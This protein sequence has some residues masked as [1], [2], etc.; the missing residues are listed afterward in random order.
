MRTATCELCG[1]MQR[2]STPVAVEV[3]NFCHARAS[4]DRAWQVAVRINHPEVGP[5]AFSLDGERQQRVEVGR[6][7]RAWETMRIR[8]HE[9]GQLPSPTRKMPVVRMTVTLKVGWSPGPS[10]PVDRLLHDVIDGVLG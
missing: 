2:V 3:H 4:L 8:D 9:T 7:N 5:T 6:Q 10:G 1:R